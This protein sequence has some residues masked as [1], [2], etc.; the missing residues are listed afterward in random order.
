MVLTAL[1]R[2][3][4]LIAITD[5]YWCDDVIQA[6]QNETR[7]VCIPGMEISAAQHIVGLGLSEPISANQTYQEIVSQIHEQGGLA[8]AAHPYLDP[9]RFDESVLVSLGVDAM[10]CWRSSLPEDDQRQQEISTQYGIPCIHN[11]DA[12]FLTDIGIR[13]MDCIVEVR[14]INELKIAI[15]GGLCQKQP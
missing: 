14:D 13:Y 12:H 6:C 11:S 15:Q 2:G 1:D 10:E 7:L 5:H 8:I 9:Y 3:F 4:D